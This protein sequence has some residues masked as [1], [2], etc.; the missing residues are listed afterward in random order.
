MCVFLFYIDDFGKATIK[1]FPLDVY[2]SFSLVHRVYRLRQYRRL[3]VHI[4]YIHILCNSLGNRVLK[5]QY[6]GHALAFR[7]S[8]VHRSLNY[9]YKIQP[10]NLTKNVTSLNVMLL[11]F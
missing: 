10:W 6:L 1:G 2:K 9:L 8:I 7:K 11:F 4:G 3:Q 5:R